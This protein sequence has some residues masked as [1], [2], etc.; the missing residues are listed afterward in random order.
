VFTVLEEPSFPARPDRLYL[1]LKALLALIL[2]GMAG[3]G[4]GL[5]REVTARSS[6]NADPDYAEFTSLGRQA[7]HDL[8]HP[9]SALRRLFG[10]S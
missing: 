7:M 8:T 2:G 6:R 3:L 5:V 10:G 4:V 9:R 1:A